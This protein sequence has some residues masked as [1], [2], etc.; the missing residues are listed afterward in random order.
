MRPRVKARTSTYVSIVSTNP[1]TLDGLQDYL[2][3]AGVACHCTDAAD[4]FAAVAPESV[5]AAVIFPDDF[6]PVVIVALI[7]ELRRVRPRL[8]SLLITRS[9]SR[10]A[11]A[12]DADGR[13]LPPIVLPRPS[14][15]W[16]ILDAIRAHVPGDG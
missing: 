4:D 13:S 10:L 9:P 2:R 16:E 7:T 15:G 3:Q 8:L 14:F 11:G 5:T 12:L 1:E 6:D